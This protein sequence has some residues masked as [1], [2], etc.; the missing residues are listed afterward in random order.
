MRT[1]KNDEHSSDMSALALNHVLYPRIKESSDHQLPKPAKQK[2]ITQALILSRTRQ[3]P[4]SNGEHTWTIR[5]MQRGLSSCT[6]L[7]RAHPCTTAWAVCST[8]KSLVKLRNVL[9]QC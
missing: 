2:H 6:A 1:V 5:A 4:E 8:Y 7:P 9:I 3:D